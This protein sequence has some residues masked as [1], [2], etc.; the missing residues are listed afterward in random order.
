M[1]AMRAASATVRTNIGVLP[2]SDAQ[3]SQSRSS[4][5]VVAE[6]II[7][8]RRRGATEGVGCILIPGRD[9]ETAHGSM[10]ESDENPMRW[11][12]VCMTVLW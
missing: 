11:N 12:G 6:A 3:R 4:R 9:S 10:G 5:S 2:R 7:D 8:N 1:Q